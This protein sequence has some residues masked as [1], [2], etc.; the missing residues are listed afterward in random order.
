[1]NDGFKKVTSTTVR[2]RNRDLPL[3]LM[4]HHI[5]LAQSTVSLQLKIFQWMQGGGGWGWWMKCEIKPLGAS[6]INLA[7][8]GIKR[9]FQIISTIDACE[10]SPLRRIKVNSATGGFPLHLRIMSLYYT[11][12]E[13]KCRS[14]YPKHRSVDIPVFIFP[15]D[16]TLLRCVGEMGN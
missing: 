9:T 2:L 5:A 12:N 10:L 3:E 15:L 11:I 16:S 7:H 8:S 1:M 6:T 14:I 13:D 4:F